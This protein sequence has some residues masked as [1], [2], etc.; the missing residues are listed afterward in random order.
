MEQRSYFCR[1]MQSQHPLT[2]QIFK[3]TDDGKVLEDCITAKQRTNEIDWFVFLLVFQNCYFKSIDMF[4]LY[5]LRISQLAFRILTITVKMRKTILINIVLMV[6]VLCTTLTASLPIHYNPG[7][8]YDFAWEK[9]CRLC[10]Y[11]DDDQTRNASMV[12]ET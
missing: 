10:F 8:M 4:I 5:V 6:I 7:L 1:H 12:I 3:Q 2:T 11:C 9:A